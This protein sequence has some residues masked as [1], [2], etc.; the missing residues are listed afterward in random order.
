MS[1]AKKAHSQFG[2]ELANIILTN[3]Y[4]LTIVYGITWARADEIAQMEWPGKVPIGHNDPRRFAAALREVLE[5]AYGQGHM[6]LAKTEAIAKAQA[7]AQPTVNTFEVDVLAHLLDEEMIL[8]NAGWLYLKRNYGIEMSTAAMIR[9][10][11]VTLRDP[12]IEWDGVA[13]RLNQYSTHTLSD[14]QVAA[15]EIALDHPLVVITGGPGTGKTT[16]LATICNILEDHGESFTLCAPTGKAARRI[17]EATSYAAGTIHRTLGLYGDLIKECFRTHYVLIDESSM[18]DASLM[19]TVLEACQPDPAIDWPGSR[20]ILIGD[21]DQLPPVGAG[22]PFYQIIQ[23]GVPTAR[24]TQIHRQGKD[25]GIVHL[26][27]AFNTGHVA[28]VGGFEDVSIQRVSNNESLPAAALKTINDLSQ[29]IRLNNI[30]VLTPVNGTDYGQLK[31][32]EQLQ[33]TYNPGP[34]SLKGL[35]FKKDDKVIHIHNVYDLH[36]R[37]VFNGMVGLVTWIADEEGERHMLHMQEELGKE[38]MP[39]V[40]CVLFDGDTISAEYTREEAMHYLRLAYA[41]TIHKSQGS[42]YENVVMLAPSVYEG[43]M[44]RQ[45]VYTGLT[46]AKQ[47]AVIITANTALERYVQNAQRVRRFTHLASMIQE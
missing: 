46:R 44:L 26:A 22:E 29:R 34:F 36:N 17:S 23:A 8:H 27:H 20:L 18:V 19:R 39:I 32:N 37:V 12:L 21:V 28:D 13:T 40:L 25:S 35:S 3:A 31:L 16:I 7:L 11:Q 5:Q 9:A 14:D 15:V 4:R 30:Q 42:E 43:F 45:L 47:T 1:Q 10:K 24:L 6:T 33:E 41:L 2:T 38:E